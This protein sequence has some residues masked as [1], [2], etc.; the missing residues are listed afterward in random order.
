[1]EEVGEKTYFEWETK[2]LED[3]SHTP[4]INFARMPYHEKLGLLRTG[5]NDVY[6]RYIKKEPITPS[7]ER[8]LPDSNICVY[9]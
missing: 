2:I 4:G 3:I 8:R 7:R 1:M 5:M 6:G 9:G